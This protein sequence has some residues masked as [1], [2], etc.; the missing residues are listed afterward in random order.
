MEA[1]KLTLTNGA[2]NFQFLEDL[3]LPSAGHTQLQSCHSMKIHLCI[4][5]NILNQ[6]LV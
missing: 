4:K 1:E 6:N 2:M 5:K 3:T